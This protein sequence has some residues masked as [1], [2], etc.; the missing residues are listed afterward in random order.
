MAEQ[1]EYS[2]RA[3]VAWAQYHQEGTNAKT[4]ARQFDV[5]GTP[6]PEQALE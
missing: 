2:F 1:E 4:V 6:F 5:V 3:Q